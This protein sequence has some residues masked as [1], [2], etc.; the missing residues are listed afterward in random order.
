VTTPKRRAGR[1]PQKESLKDD[2][3]DMNYLQK[4][5]LCA[6]V[7]GAVSLSAVAQNAQPTTPTTNAPN[8]NQRKD[9]QQ[10]RIGEGVENGSLTAGE[11][12]RLERK[13]TKLNVE[14]KRMKADGKLTPAERAR[15][16]RQQNGLSR[17]IYN[18]KH[19]AQSQNVNPKSEVGKR[20]RAQ[21]QRIG[22][23][24]ENGSLNSREASRLER[25]ET[26]LNREVARDRA[27]NGGV[28]TPAEKG[29]INRQQN[30]E[31]K[32]IYR[33]KHDAQ[34]RR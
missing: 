2:G 29:K 34:A 19:D 16:Q 9:N 21:Q 32:R 31:S 18:Q 8:I 24:I 6:V 15:L 4:G 3:D 22:E 13:E 33:Q 17:Q 11:A 10:Q 7:L 26:H 1:E 5:T 12:A 28:L 27:A 23:G 30:R 25:Q 20:Q 14:E